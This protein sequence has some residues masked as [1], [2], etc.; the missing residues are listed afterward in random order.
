MEPLHTIR[1]QIAQILVKWD[2]PTRQTAIS[3]ITQLVES[4]GNAVRSE[5]REKIQNTQERFYVVNKKTKEREY[6]GG[7][8]CRSCDK[9]KDSLEIDEVLSS[10]TP[11]EEKI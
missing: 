2:M 4:Y 10:L 5:I 11:N 8:T 6:E 1:D 9:R 3:E 7:G